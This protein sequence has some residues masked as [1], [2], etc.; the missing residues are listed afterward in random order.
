MAVVRFPWRWPEA[1]P[2]FAV[3]LAPSPSSANIVERKNATILMSA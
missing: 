3:V 1:V 2:F